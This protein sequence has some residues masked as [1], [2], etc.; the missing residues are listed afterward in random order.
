MAP[1]CVDHS[2]TWAGLYDTDTSL[3]AFTARGICNAHAQR[4]IQTRIA[5]THKVQ[6]PTHRELR[7]FDPKINEFS[8]LIVEH[9]YVKFSDP[10]CIVFRNIA[11]KKNRQTGGEN[12]TLPIA[13]SLRNKVECALHRIS[14][15]PRRHSRRR[16]Q[17]VQ[18][19][20]SACL[21]VRALKG[22][23]LKLR[24]PNLV[25]VYSIAVAQHALT[26]R[27]KSQRS[28]SHGY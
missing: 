17:G 7:P 5:S 11:Q 18:S 6:S 14:Y 13:D 28:R 10:S 1:R 26:Q 12:R 16:G 9:L 8:G 3:S 22:K 21:F 24:T 25:H 20:L 2:A 4:S 19:R 15:Y 23:Q 27:S